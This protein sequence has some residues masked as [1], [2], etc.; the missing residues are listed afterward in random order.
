MS[1]RFHNEIRICG[2][3]HHEDVDVVPFVG[4]FS[5]EAHPFCLVYE[6]MSLDLRQHLGNEQNVGGLKLVPIPLY[7]LGV[8]LLTFL[9]TAEGYC[10]KFEVLAQS[11]YYP[12]RFQD[13]EPSTHPVHSHHVIHVRLMF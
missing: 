6:R 12:R 7:A 8:S 3:L 2:L 4:V 5:T 10:S 9:T 1:Q 13:S 11:R